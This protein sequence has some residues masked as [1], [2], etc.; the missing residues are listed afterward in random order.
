MKYIYLHGLGQT[1]NSWDSVIKLLNATEHSICPNLAEFVQGKNVTYHTL[2][3]A[4]KT[5]CDTIQEPLCLCGLSLGGV[6]SLHYAIE[7]PQKVKALVLIA[8]QYKMPKNLLK[9]QNFLFR[10][11]PKSMFEQMGFG[12]SDFLHLCKSM[13][14][15]DFSKSLY[16]ISCPVLIICGEKD[17]ANKNASLELSGILANGKLEL[18]DG[19]G[20]EVNI[21]APK[22]L[23]EVMGEFYDS[24]LI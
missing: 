9:F 8:T 23:A 19:V 3:S 6:L 15:L 14:K 24:I 4:F 1:P 17:T 10:F 16:K 5:M 21:E 13:M 18:L 2:Y 22:K 11:M 12:K 20:H 7:H